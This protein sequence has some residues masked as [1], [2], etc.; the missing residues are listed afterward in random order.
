MY[1]IAWLT[2]DMTLLPE[3]EQALTFVPARL[4][5]ISDLSALP[6]LPVDLIL[7]QDT[8]F[9]EEAYLMLKHQ[10]PHVI[11]LV[12]H[13]QRQD[14]LCPITS[15]GA[16]RWYIVIPFDPEELGFIIGLLLK[17]T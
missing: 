6:S 17:Q 16:P 14:R 5:I 1:T 7:W 11:H 12:E 13:R 2:P 10:C 8:M 9:D 3:V 4:V 15:A